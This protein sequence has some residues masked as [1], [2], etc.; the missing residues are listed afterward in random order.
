MIN[1][2]LHIRE[3]QWTPR[4]LNSN[5]STSRDIVIKLSKDKVG[6][7]KTDTRALS[8][9]ETLDKIR[10]IFKKEGQWNNIYTKCWNGKK[11]KYKIYIHQSN[12]SKM[13]ETL[14]QKMMRELH[15]ITSIPQESLTDS[16]SKLYEEIKNTDKGYIL[17]LSINYNIKYILYNI[18]YMYNINLSI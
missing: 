8:I 18:Y 3:A 2:I 16:K 11:L 13:K 7:L 5:S 9:K 12:I 14:R 4:R 17:Y 15:T 1:N 10:G 6:I